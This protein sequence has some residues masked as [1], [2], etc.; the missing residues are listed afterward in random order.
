MDLLKSKET[1]YNATLVCMED[2]M[3]VLNDESSRNEERVQSLL[4]KIATM[5]IEMQSLQEQLNEEV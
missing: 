3:Q 1:E 2:E 5:E 4:T